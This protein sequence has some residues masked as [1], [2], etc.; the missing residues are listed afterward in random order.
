M[1][2]KQK[3]TQDGAIGNIKHYYELFRAITVIT[4]VL[5]TTWKI[6]SENF[7]N[8]SSKAIC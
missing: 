8:F 3:W 2:K 1:Q 7:I 4:D 6:I 5:F